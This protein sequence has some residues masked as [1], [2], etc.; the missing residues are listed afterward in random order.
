M[1]ENCIER[2]CTECGKKLKF[3]GYYIN[4]IQ[5][6]D[7]CICEYC[8][9]KI[10][11]KQKRYSKFIINSLIG[12]SKGTACFILISAAPAFEEKIL[13][14]LSKLPEIVEIQPLLGWY[15]IIAK[16]KAKN[17][18]NLGN[19]IERNIKSIEGIEDTITLTGSF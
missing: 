12:E 4:S 1:K 9:D 17:Y 10:Q 15:D 7:K 14:R 11:D 13:N 16:I 6:K 19:F 3:L 18:K 2:K 5:I 8:L